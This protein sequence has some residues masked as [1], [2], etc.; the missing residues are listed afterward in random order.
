MLVSGE[1][2]GM[3][4]LKDQMKLYAG[5]EAFLAKNLAPT[6]GSPAA[7]ATP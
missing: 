7:P 5:I 2:H 1:G 6:A 3:L 4:Y